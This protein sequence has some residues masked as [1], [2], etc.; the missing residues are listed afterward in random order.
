MRN[1]TIWGNHS[2]TQYPDARHA[3]VTKGSVESK[4]VDA[5]NDNA[6]LQDQF[7]TVR[8]QIL[9]RRFNG[10]DPKF[11][12]NMIQEIFMNIINL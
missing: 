5:I 4:V 9:K 6:W 7:I 1:V 11:G 3:L 2:S 10:L 8:N 12:F